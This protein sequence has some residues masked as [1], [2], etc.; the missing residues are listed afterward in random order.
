MIDPIDIWRTA[1]ILIKDYGED[2]SWMAARRADMFLDDGN[3]EAFRI[4]TQIFCAIDDL[5]RAPSNGD[6]IN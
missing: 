2:A 5:E 1:H 4:W 6:T 3:M